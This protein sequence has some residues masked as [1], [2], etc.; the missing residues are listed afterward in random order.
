MTFQRTLFAPI[1]ALLLCLPWAVAAVH[2][3][4]LSSYAVAQRQTVE[5]SAVERAHLLTEMNAFLGAINGINAALSSKDF[6]QVETLAKAMG[7]KGGHS[8][9]VAKA[10]HDKLPSEW[11][12]LAKP[13][14]QN[15]L[16]IANE[17]RNNPS[18]EAVLG[19]VAA[20]TQQCVACHSAFQL[21]V[22]P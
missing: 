9:P 8:D 5:V 11:F 15:F 22:A 7:P 12:A 18:V 6:E 20:T 1:S 10:V 19:K 2:A 3:D 17:A 4:T 13:T 14:H 16:A 21:T